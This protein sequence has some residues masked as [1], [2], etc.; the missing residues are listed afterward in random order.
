MMEMN[1]A[2]G[3]ADREPGASGEVF[4][5]GRAIYRH[6]AGVVNT[7]AVRGALAATVDGR[8][9]GWARIERGWWLALGCTMLVF[10]A[11]P[12]ANL[13]LG[14][15]TK[16]YGLWYQVG[17]AI[18]QG[19]DVY[20]R[21]ETHRL[22]PF[23]YPPSAAAMLAWLS[24]LGRTGSLLALV[25]V[26][27]AAWLASIVLSVYLAVKPGAGRHPLVVILPSLC[28]IVL[29]HNIYLLGQPNLL[30]LALL[31]GAFVCLQRGRSVAAGVL[32]ATAAAIKAFPI[33]A[34]GYLVYR[35]MWAA[36]TATVLA[37]AAWLLIAPLPFRTPTQVIDDVVVWSKG[38]LFTYNS[39]GIA[40]RP[41]RSYSYKNQSIMALSHR[42]LRA[43]PADGE[44]VLSRREKD[45]QAESRP[46]KGIAGV[47]PSTDLLAFLKAHAEDPPSPVDANPAFPADLAAA[48][49]GG[50]GASAG[51]GGAEHSLRWEDTIQAA[52]LALRNAWKV[53][54]LDLSFRSVTV[55]TLAFMV[56]LC[57]FVL[58]VLPRKGNRTRETDAIEYAIVVLLTVMFSP[59][60]FNYA[61]VWLIYPMTLGL[62]LVM[63]EPSGAR[64]HR[65][66]VAWIAAVFLIPALALPMP[67]LAQAYGNL[68][69]PALLLL[70][71]L[72]A[73]LRAMRS[74]SRDQE[75]MGDSAR[76]PHGDHY[77][78]PVTAAT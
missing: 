28:I 40:Q 53:N 9:A 29:V 45:G 74:G 12:I 65:I 59:L 19:L 4:S 39:R 5:T 73:M 64:G 47:D 23:M 37:L 20:P 2:N 50:G 58:A 48:A 41:F 16:D 44:A 46:T 49:A 63:S 30:L 71:G 7:K 70:L 11:F 35:R 14:F 24:M 51:N 32:V 34:L 42:L 25:I 56:G 43:V 6:D 57:G 76:P 68:F 52:E 17:L 60:S 33:M 55:V 36:S 26:N 15:S 22:F 21:P 69:V 54:L 27:S 78:R 18:R 72:G 31:L 8:L 61:Y 66:R 1:D 62:H 3:F 75:S 67:V 10:A 38:M 77:S 13:V